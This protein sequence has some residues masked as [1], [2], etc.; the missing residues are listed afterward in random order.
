MGRKWDRNEKEKP[1]E[2]VFPLSKRVGGVC[3][4]E[5]VLAD[6]RL[7][8]WQVTLEGPS[9]HTAQRKR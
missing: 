9:G 4:E 3:R 1:Q 7:S 2:R 6:P 8:V 5:R